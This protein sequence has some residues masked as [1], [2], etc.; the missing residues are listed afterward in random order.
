MD[1]IRDGL[2]SVNPIAIGMTPKRF[3]NIRSDFVAAENASDVIPVKNERKAALSPD[4]LELFTRLS[5]RRAHFGLSRLGRY[6]SAKGI[7]P[8]EIN[9]DIFEGLMTAVR[10]GSLHQ[11]PKALHRQVTLIWNESAQ[12]PELGLKPVTVASFRGPPKRVD[13]A[14]LPTSFIEDRDTYLSWCVA[15]DPFAVDAR[16]RPLASRTLKLS[17]DQIHAAVTAL[18][19]ER[20]EAGGHPLARRSSHC[21]QLS[22]VFCDSV[23]QTQGGP[24]LYAG[25][26]GP[27][28]RCV[29]KTSGSWNSTHTCLYAAN[30]GLLRPSN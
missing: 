4:W 18:G 20:D 14:L 27:I 29:R 8:G 15:T 16:P 25:A 10:E 11:N 12:N 17:R 3:A 13:L 6:A 30:P 7:Q 9:D 23:S 2:G 22:E 28:C 26:S 5:G 24:D 1:T 21:P 19:Q